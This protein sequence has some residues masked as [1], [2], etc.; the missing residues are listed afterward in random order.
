MEIIQASTLHLN[1]V[2]VLFDTYR[3]FYKAAP[4]FEGALKF[5]SER[6]EKGESRIYVA[7]ESDEIIGFMQLY[8]I[9]TSLGMKRAWVLNDLFV[10][11][12]HRGK[13]AGGMLVDAARQLAIDTEAGYVA[14]QTEVTNET[15]QRLYEEKG[16]KKDTDFYYYYLSV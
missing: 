5:I 8:P 3:S 12:A 1:E 7:L 15:A 2:A 9:F 16:F 11:E 13:G 4:D 10:L 6:M 14:L